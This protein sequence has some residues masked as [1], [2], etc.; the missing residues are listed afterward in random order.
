MS[1]LLLRLAGPLQ[2]WG[3]TSRFTRR[4][5]ETAPSRSGVLGMIAAAQGRRRTDPLTD[6]L[7]LR[8]A[9]RVDQP[10]HLERDFQTA[11]S[12]D[13]SKA[14]PL[15]HRYYLA[16]AVFVAGIEGDPE[17]IAG[18]EHALRRPAFPLYLG[19]RSCPPTVPLVLGIREG[20]LYDELARE[21]WQ[22]ADWWKRKQRGQVRDLDLLADV[23]V[24]P[25][26]PGQIREEPIRQR[27]VPVSFDPTMR[28]YGW[29]E[30][31]R[32]TV[33]PPGEATNTP[34]EHDAMALLEAD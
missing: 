17:L 20:N 22:A 12:L 13:G 3:V 24:I 9:V 31:E 26:Q 19:R 15:S 7:D 14:H 6:L 34:I 18:I 27:D 23:G 29:R 21:P 11:R 1:V 33:P 16:D 2:S 25:Q 30:I 28:Q 8:F 32:T 4:T 10:G 5:T